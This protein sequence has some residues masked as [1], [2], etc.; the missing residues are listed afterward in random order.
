MS[1]SGL[2]SGNFVVFVKDLYGIYYFEIEV[3]YVNN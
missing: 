1:V 2:D 3:S